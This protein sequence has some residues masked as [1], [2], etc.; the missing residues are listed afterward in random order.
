MACRASSQIEARSA[1]AFRAYGRFSFACMDAGKGR[2]QERKLWF[3]FFVR[4]KKMNPP[5]GAGP[6]DQL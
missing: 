1:E 5:A 3:V 2:E 4:T 6:G